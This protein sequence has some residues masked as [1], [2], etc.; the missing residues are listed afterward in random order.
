[1]PEFIAPKFSLADL[2]A[3]LDQIQKDL[4]ETR[5]QMLYMGEAVKLQNQMLDIA[6]NAFNLIADPM[7]GCDWAA[8][9]TAL[10]ALKRIGM[11]KLPDPNTFAVSVKN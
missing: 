9:Q 4:I 5:R 8:K 11:I 1:M 6:I 10:A 3:Q 7:T 2:H